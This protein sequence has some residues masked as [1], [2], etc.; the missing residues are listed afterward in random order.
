VFLTQIKLYLGFNLDKFNLEIEQVLYTV[1]LLEGA[2]VSWIE[3]FV[4]DYITHRNATG[5]VTTNSDKT[6]IDLQY[7]LRKKG[8]V[9]ESLRSLATSTRSA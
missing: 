2:A 4:A 7:S 5:A 9:R 6:T 3:P 8:S 1:T